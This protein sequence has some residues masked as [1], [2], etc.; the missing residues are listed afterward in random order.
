MPDTYWV[1]GHMEER[2]TALYRQHYPAVARYVARRAG[3]V[4]TGEVV[5]QVFLTAWRRFADVP[6]ESP[7]PWLY[8]VAGRVLANEIRGIQ[9]SRRLQ[10][11]VEIV[12]PTHDLPDHSGRIV[13]EVAMRAAFDGLSERDQEILRLIAWEGLTVAEAALVLGCGRTTVAMRVRRLRRKFQ[14]LRAPE[15]P[16]EERSDNDLVG[17]VR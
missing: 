5:A 7:L 2:F 10:Q 17:R 14:H 12:A 13:E 11:R 4:D 15:T 16:D 6:Q 8:A 9:R 3:D 1:E